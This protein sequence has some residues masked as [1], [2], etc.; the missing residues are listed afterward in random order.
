MCHAVLAA[1]SGCCSPRIGRLLT[2]YSP[3]RHS[4]ISLPPRRTSQKCFVRLECVKHAASVH[5]EPGSNSLKNLY[6]LDEV[7][8]IADTFFQ[9]AILAS[10]LL[11]YF[12][13]K[14]YIN[15]I[16]ILCF[17]LLFNFQGPFPLPSAFPSQKRLDYSI[18]FTPILSREFLKFFSFFSH[19]L[20]F[21]I[22]YLY[23]HN[24]SCEK[25]DELFIRLPKTTGKIIFPD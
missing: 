2:R 23:S 21:R 14:V 15:E 11:K 1:V 9:S 10:Y 6:I 18:T 24:F 25:G 17:S 13:F 20:F 4:V 3:V 5:P 8:F 7:S 16:L 12:V 19:F 22:F